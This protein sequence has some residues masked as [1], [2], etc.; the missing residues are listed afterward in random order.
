MKKSLSLALCLLLLGLGALPAQ[1]VPEKT[2]ENPPARELSIDLMKMDRDARCGQVLV[3]CLVNGTPMRMLL[4]TGATH[5]VL[6]DES[7][8]KLKNPQWLDVSQMRFKG[9]SAQQPKILIASLNVGPG[10]SPVHPVVVI[11]LA[12]VRSMMAGKVDGIVGMDILSSLPF[13]FDLRKNECYWGTPSEGNSVPLRGKRDASGRLTLSVK[14]G[15]KTFPILLDTGSSVT[16]I[17]SGNWTPGIDREI[18]A[19][20]GDVDNASRKKMIQGK[21]ARLEIASGVFLKPVSPL[22]CDTAE[23]AI[24]GMDALNGSALIHIPSPKEAHGEFFLIAAP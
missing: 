21:S 5:T 15:E 18:T 11:S 3:N 7:A 4:D 16:R 2:P 20:V 12:A 23:E 6:H 14:S 22:L 8:S 9:N 19:H 24:L 13:T 1:E 17:F 10:V